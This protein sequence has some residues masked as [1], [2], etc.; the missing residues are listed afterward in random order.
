MFKV[1]TEMAFSKEKVDIKIIVK[2]HLG[3]LLVIALSLLGY[4]YVEY[5]EF[6]GIM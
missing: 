5:D 2:N 4:F 3:S 6:L 1:S